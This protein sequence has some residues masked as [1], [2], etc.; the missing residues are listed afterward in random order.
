MQG[1]HND[2]RDVPEALNSHHPFVS[3]FPDQLTLI[4]DE[5]PDSQDWCNQINDL[6]NSVTQMSVALA[7]QDPGPE[8]QIRNM[9]N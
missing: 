1:M 6:R 5:S 9:I 8:T 4:I 7:L 3:V 2:I